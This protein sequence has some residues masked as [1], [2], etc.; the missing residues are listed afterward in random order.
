MLK[1]WSSSPFAVSKTY[2]ATRFLVD[3][4]SVP[5]PGTVFYVKELCFVAGSSCYGSSSQPAG[6]ALFQTTAVGSVRGDTKA[7]T[8]GSYSLQVMSQKIDSDTFSRIF[9]A[10]RTRYKKDHV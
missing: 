8:D 3:K 10:L 4:Q 6:G 9:L 7:L 2:Y 5:Y 1:L